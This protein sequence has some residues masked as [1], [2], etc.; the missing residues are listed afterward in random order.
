MSQK[1][2]ERPEIQILCRYLFGIED[3][4]FPGDIETNDPDFEAAI[5]AKAKAEVV[6]NRLVTAGFEPLV[7]G[8]ANDDDLS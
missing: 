3:P 7:Y 1:T 6:L 2:T 8:I 5:T 4:E